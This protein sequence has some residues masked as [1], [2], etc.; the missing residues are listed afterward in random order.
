MRVTILKT[1]MER[2][3]GP[4]KRSQEYSSASIHAV[5]TNQTFKALPKHKTNTVKF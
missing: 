1:Q 5:P 2:S 3:G 4:T